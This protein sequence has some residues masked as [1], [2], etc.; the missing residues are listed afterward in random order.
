MI[1]AAGLGTR[2]RPLTETVPKA[3]VEVGDVPML[4][5]VARRLVAVG[6]DRLIVNVH[7]RADQ[8]ETF[9]AETDTGAEVAIS[10]E[11]DR[12]LGTGG[13]LARAAP[14]FRGEEPFLLHNV[15]VV[16]DLDL[17][18]L[19]AAQRGTEALAT[20]AVGRRET[21]RFLLFDAEGLYG[22]EN[23]GTGESK[24]VRGPVGTS[25]RWPFAGVH[26]ITPR[27]FEWMPSTG[28]AVVEPFSIVEVY[29]RATAAGERVVPWDLGRATWMEVGNPERLERARRAVAAGAVPLPE[30]PA[31]QGGTI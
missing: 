1:L 31:A 30:P 19:R 17:A 8:V 5:R 22:W 12:P 27:I 28:S 29:L 21:S 2:L 18:G 6:A 25:E 9:L 10:F 7:H 15:D 11:T 4:E 16:S 24:A 3:L 23:A 26:A 20:L 14:L 13:G